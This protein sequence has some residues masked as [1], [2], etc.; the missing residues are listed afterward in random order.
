MFKHLL[1]PTDGSAGSERAI[2][3]ALELA[4]ECGVKVTGLHVVQP[5]HLVSHDIDMVE[6]TRA[7]F[8]ANVRARGRQYLDAIER[9]AEELGVE[10]ST[11]IVVAD[12]P[13]RAIID[14]ARTAGCDLIVMASHGRRGMRA[15]LLGSET[16]KVLTHGNTPVLVLR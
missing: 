1:L 10:V 15:V 13:Y 11:R 7:S 6:Q 4:R 12:H 3:R 2:A 14:T 8:E 9:G 5:F 16:Q